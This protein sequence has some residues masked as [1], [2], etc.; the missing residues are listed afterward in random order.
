MSIGG[1]TNALLTR[2]RIKCSHCGAA[3]V[4]QKDEETIIKNRLMIISRRKG[5]IKIK[6]KECGTLQIISRI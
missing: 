4:I 2:Q 3:L 1:I 5:V 6:C